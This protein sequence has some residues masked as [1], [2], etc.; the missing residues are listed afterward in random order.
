MKWL[1]AITLLGISISSHSI[2]TRG[3][4]DPCAIEFLFIG[5]KISNWLK[6][7]NFSGVD[8][9]K[10][11]DQISILRQSL[12][13]PSK[14]IQL[15]FTDTSVICGGIPKAGCTDENNIVTINRGYWLQASAEEKIEL[16]VLEV[17]QMMG[18]VERYSIA[19]QVGTQ[20]SLLTE[21]TSSVCTRSFVV[22]SELERK[23]AKSCDQITVLDLAK[24]TELNLA[25]RG[26]SSLKAGDF[27]GLTGLQF[28][29][30]ESNYLTQ[31]P[32]GIFRDLLQLQSL[33][34]STNDLTKIA[35]DTFKGMTRLT[36]LSIEENRLETVP[37]QALNNLPQLINLELNGN[38]ISLGKD[39]FKGLKKIENLNL[40]GNDIS[41]LDENQFADLP[42]LK[43]LN[44]S[45]N[46]LI[47]LPAHVFAN[48]S[49]LMDL[50]LS[51]NQISTL[52]DPL[53]N[54]AH[55]IQFLTLSYNN[56]T[57]LSPAVVRDLKISTCTQFF[58]DH[59]IW[60]WKNPLTTQSKKFLRS[61]FGEKIYF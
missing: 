30:L 10:F 4:G 58:C 60:L 31:L 2:G 42:S 15:I 45:S 56:L 12:D 1:L 23:L 19:Q 8:Q 21:T 36:H 34:L 38:R 24:I 25:G 7:S 39:D 48:Q 17:F 32:D 37:R 41:E 27:D 35:T 26:I 5:D 59:V 61:Q 57:G 28:L 16:V 22:V 50:D 11:H 46:K 40:K 6:S 44:L 14:N 3:G 33:G 29:S 52:P 51:Y 49:N 9:I 53:F 13:D 55:A 47:S 54:G 43:W 18:L 20:M